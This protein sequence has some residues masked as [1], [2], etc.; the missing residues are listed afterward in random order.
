MRVLFTCRPGYGHYYPLLPL[1]RAAMAGGHAVAFATGEPIRGVAEADGFEAFSAGPGFAAIREAIVAR[2]GPPEEIPRE[3]H[4]S[5]FFGRVFTGI[6]LPAR[7]PELLAIADKWQ[8]DLIVHEL[9]EFAG[10][11]TAKI[12]GIPHVTCGYGPLLEPE[13]ANIAQ[14]AAGEHYRAAGVA[15]AAARLYRSLYLDPCPPRLQVPAAAAI[16]RRVAVR[17]EPA[18]TTA[19]A[20]P[21]WLRSLPQQPTVYVTLGTVWNQDPSFFRI[22]LGSLAARP[23]NVIAALGPGK[24]PAG[25]GPQPPNVRICGFVPHAQL[26]GHC[27]LVVCHGGAG[28]VLDALSAGLPLLVVPQAADHFYNASRVVAAGAGRSTPHASLTP[29]SVCREIDILMQDAGYRDAAAAIA[30]EIAAMPP[31][32]DALTTLTALADRAERSR[33]CGSGDDA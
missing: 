10:P 7:L 26:L 29:A 5:F 3:Q 19:A 27:D 12:T 32:R 14:R 21:G 22:V 1:A 2:Y 8:P 28:S 30:A 24:D 13:I 25:L 15:P 4:R 16:E 18:G 33:T 31:A 23:V 20:G 9:S 17:P 6:E 11:L